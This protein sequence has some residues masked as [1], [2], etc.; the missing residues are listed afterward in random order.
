MVTNDLAHGSCQFFQDQK[1]AQT[2]D[3]VHISFGLNQI[4]ELCSI[5]K[6]QCTEEH[7][8]N[9]GIDSELGR[10]LTKIN[11]VQEVIKGARIIIPGSLFFQSTSPILGP[12]PSYPSS[13]FLSPHA[14]VLARNCSSVIYI[15]S[16]GTLSALVR[17]VNCC[18]SLRAN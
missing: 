14:G 16:C 3:R 2:K 7:W 8:M 12:S 17:L 5:F 15:I 4:F 18:K 9:H 11:Q 1:N 13:F 10:S 6:Q